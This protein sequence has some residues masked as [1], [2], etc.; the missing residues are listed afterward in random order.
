MWHPAPVSDPQP[1]E[2]TLSAPT[3]GPGDGELSLEDLVGD[4]LTVPD[5]AERLGVRLADVRRM[6][7]D[8]VLLAH[9]IGQR[10]VVAVPAA[11]FDEE[12]ALAALPGTITVLGDA[13]LEDAEMLR[14]LFTADG[15]LPLGGTPVDNI[16]GGR[17]TEVRRRA[18]ELA[19]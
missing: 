19:L 10:R 13:G 11:F 18:M 17:K 7:E 14:W 3:E 16:R 2:V 9:R 12:G 1:P 4:W 6:I 8:R 5:I 15:T